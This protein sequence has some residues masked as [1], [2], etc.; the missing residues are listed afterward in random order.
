MEQGP[1]GTLSRGQAL[2][3]LGGIALGAALAA[4]GAREWERLNARETL[5]VA[6]A[7][8][9]GSLMEGPVKEA[10][11]R[12]FGAQWIGRAQGSS[13]LARLIEAGAIHPDVFIA[14]TPS[15]MRLVLRAGK[16]RTATPIARTAMVIAYSPASRYAPSFAAAGEHNALPWWRVLEEPGVRFGRTDPSTDPQGRNIIFTLMLAAKLYQ[17]DDLVTRVLGAPLNPQQIFPEPTVL[18][19]VQAGELDASSA[20]RVQPGPFN[21]PYMTLPDAVNLGSPARSAAY[22][23][24]S[25]QLGDRS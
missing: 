25:L 20:Y 13:A 1:G 5:E 21:L 10:V 9:M 16:A 24:V 2:L 11:E 15:P 8:S 22:S 23:Q 12:K 18:A 7:G 14:A 17:Q 6:Y 4:S 3:R 19:R